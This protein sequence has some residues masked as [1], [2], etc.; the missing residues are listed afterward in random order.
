MSG[1]DTQL[2]R[3]T[4]LGGATKTAA[5]SS[6]VTKKRGR[7]SAMEAYFRMK[8]ARQ[9][10]GS[11]PDKDNMM[12]FMMQMQDEQEDRERQR[13]REDVCAREERDVCVAHECSM[14]M[15]QM[16]AAL[17]NPAAGLAL[18]QAGATPEQ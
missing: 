15:M 8:Q 7:P 9:E 4:R 10:K 18:M 14:Q 1:S 11:G 13:T 16:L 17:I 2:N 6:A 12:L 5:L 3:S